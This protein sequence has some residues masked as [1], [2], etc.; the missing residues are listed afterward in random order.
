MR[1]PNNCEVC[2]KEESI[3]F[4]IRSKIIND[5]DGKTNHKC[6]IC[7]TELK[8]IREVIFTKPFGLTQ[9][10]FEEAEQNHIRWDCHECHRA[11]LFFSNHVYY[12][13]QLRHSVNKWNLF[14]ELTPLF[15][16]EEFHIGKNCLE[17]LGKK[18]NH[19]NHLT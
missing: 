5:I 2:G 1:V 8:F 15:F 19:I 16:K 17:N 7:K 18:P 13:N 3:A 9:N 12:W 14:A 6:P 10:E 11:W 4:I